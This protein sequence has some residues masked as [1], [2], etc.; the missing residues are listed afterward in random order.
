MKIRKIYGI[1]EQN[2]V[3]NLWKSVLYSY[4]CYVYIQIESKT[5]EK[6]KV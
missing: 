2:S 4:K 1:Y 5:K 3:E 6:C